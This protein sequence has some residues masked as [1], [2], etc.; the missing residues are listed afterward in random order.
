MA[1]SSHKQVY[2]QTKE[3]GMT[4]G[5][6]TQNIAVQTVGTRKSLDFFLKYLWKI[7]DIK[8]NDQVTAE[9]SAIYILILSLQT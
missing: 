7:A 2:R 6:C 1:L 8:Q 5:I 3:N 9:F 4:G